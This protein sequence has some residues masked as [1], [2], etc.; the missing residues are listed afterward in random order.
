MVTFALRKAV[1]GIL[2]GWS[3]V[4]LARSIL[5]IAGIVVAGFAAAKPVLAGELR[6]DEAKRFIAGKH[7]NYT[8]F[9]GTTG[10]GRINADGSVAGTIQ[11]RGLGAVHFVTLPPGTIRVQSDSICASIHGMWFQPCFSVNQIDSKS[12]RGS[13]SGLG[14]AYC[15]F[16]RRNP[17]LELTA[18]PA[19]RRPAEDAMLRASIGE[20]PVGEH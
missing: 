4:M 15:D 6:P 13:I 18:T 20:I 5:M 3:G 9:D 8:C 1:K 7:F 16:T 19:P 10:G 12:F 17:R 2:K 11:V 14:F